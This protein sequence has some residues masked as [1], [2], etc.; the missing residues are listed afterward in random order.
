[1]EETSSNYT[2]RNAKNPQTERLRKRDN[3]TES[4]RLTGARNRKKN[5]KLDAFL[6][7]SFYFHKKVIFFYYLEEA[8]L[9]CYIYHGV[10]GKCKYLC[11]KGERK[12][13][14]MSQC[15]GRICCV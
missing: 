6:K 11:D 8:F 13:Y 12:V 4:Q 5:Y 1:M 9:G 14:G 3:V 15:K 7:I 10:S 2:G